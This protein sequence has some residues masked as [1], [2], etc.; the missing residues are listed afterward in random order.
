[1]ISEAMKAE[2]TSLAE[3]YKALAQDMVAVLRKHN[4]TAHDI[5]FSLDAPYAG[6]FEQARMTYNRGRHGSAGII[7]LVVTT[8][9][10]DF[11]EATHD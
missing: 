4:A 3:R 5:T 11:P 6:P 1:M 10:G 8:R 9:I 7:N 2:G